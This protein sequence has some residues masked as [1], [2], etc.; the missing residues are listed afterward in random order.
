[1]T[2]LS[3]RPPRGPID[4]LVLDG[5]F[6]QSLAA[7]RSLGRHG[8]R[9]G[10][11]A[12]RSEADWAPALR[13]R[14]CRV[15]A[16]VPDVQHAG[17]YVAAV[18]DLL[19]RHPSRMV[20]PSHDGSIQALRAR[21]A[22]FE[23]RTFLPLASEAALDIAVSKSR[24]LALAE[25]LGIAV[26]RGVVVTQ[27]ADVPAAM[28]EVGY[29]AVVKPISSWGR[30][31]GLG[32]RRGCEAVLNDEQAKAVVEKIR[33][34][35]LQ[36]IIQQ[37]LPGRRDAVSFFRASGKTWARFAQTSYREWPALG[38]SSV[39][40]ESIPLLTDLIEPAERLVD[41]AGL[42]G[43]SMVEFRRDDKGR[44][45]LMEV[46]ARMPGSVALAISCGVD[47][48]AMLYAWASRAPLRETTIYRIGRRQR[49]LSGD[50][51]HLKDTF[52][53]PPGPDTPSRTGAVA[54]FLLDFV[55]R[56]S[57]FDVFDATDMRPALCEWRHSLIEA[58]VGRV[59]KGALRRRRGIS[60]GTD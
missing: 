17:D 50:V 24:T 55:R 52:A 56:P 60:E 41:A 33:S 12:C 26:P 58:A 34:A 35:G 2:Y 16:V 37:W 6:R 51:W 49:W 27:P 42:D 3:G 59:R 48:P 25:Q 46:N 22:E 40:Y 7:V 5:H 10:A 20:I 9:V 18:L 28:S 44:P 31:D 1:V 38:G 53:E 32:L 36:A 54:T 43:C 47:F 21:R 30:R 4:V 39:L 23:S 19:D 13:S 29:P 11:A 57:T 8:V 15:S 14:F 45:V